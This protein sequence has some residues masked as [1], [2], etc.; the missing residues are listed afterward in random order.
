MASASEGSDCSSGRGS[1]SDSGHKAWHSFSSLAICVY[2]C[3]HPYTDSDIDTHTNT[4]RQTQILSLWSPHVL[5]RELGLV[6][7]RR[8]GHLHIELNAFE[9]PPSLSLSFSFSVRVKR[10]TWSAT[11]HSK[12]RFA[13]GKVTKIELALKMRFPGTQHGS[14][15]A[16]L[17]C[18]CAQ[19][20][21]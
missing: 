3:A 6:S 10:S 9:T 12:M 2:L 11:R 16:L 18:L 19:L 21:A 14:M 20:V 8:Q 4:H 7:S 5:G 15:K 17:P 13:C 1:N